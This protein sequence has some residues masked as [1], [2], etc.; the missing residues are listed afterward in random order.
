M[1][2]EK[3]FWNDKSRKKNE[4][5]LKDEHHRS[6]KKY[7]NDGYK[8]QNSK[9]NSTKSNYTSF[10][11]NLKKKNNYDDMKNKLSDKRNNKN[12]FLQSFK[13]TMRNQK[14]NMSDNNSKNN[15]S[16][17]KEKYIRSS[18]EKSMKFNFYGNYNNSNNNNYNSDNYNNSNDNNYNNNSNYYSNS[19]DNNNDNNV[20]SNKKDINVESSILNKDMY[21]LMYYPSSIEENNLNM[22]NMG[23]VNN[24]VNNYNNQEENNMGMVINGVVS[25][26]DNNLSNEYI[27]NK[28]DELIYQNYLQMQKYNNA[29]NDF[30]TSFNNFYNSYK[31][32]N[33]NNDMNIKNK[34]CNNTWPPDNENDNVLNKLSDIRNIPFNNSN[35]G[36]KNFCVNDKTTMIINEL[37]KCLNNNESNVYSENNN[38]LN[39]LTNDYAEKN[40][41]NEN[42]KFF[43]NNIAST[44]KIN[45]NKILNE[46]NDNSNNN[47]FTLN[48]ENTAYLQNNKEMTYNNR[49]NYI[50]NDNKS[51][52]ES[53]ISNESSVED[54]NDYDN[55]DKANCNERIFPKSKIEESLRVL[56]TLQVDIERVCCYIKHFIDP[57]EQLFQIMTNVFLDKT[58]T[59]NSKIAIFYVYNHLI[60]E[61]RNN[62]KNDLN[63]YN[64]I[65]EKGLQIFV[66]P[67]LRYILDEKIN[68]EMINKFYRCISI[69]NE[70]NIYSKIVCDQLK[71]LQK[72]PHKKIDLKLKH[73]VNQAHSLLSNEFSK[74]L[75]L[76]FILKMPSINN[77]HKKAL[78]DKILNTLFNN[79]SKETL[80]SFDNNDIEEASK[81]SDKV[82]RIFGQELILINSQMLELSSLIS[83]NH[84][85]LIKLQNSMEKLKE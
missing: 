85:N 1:K 27:T 69:W 35:N 79:L 84:E 66:I 39:E 21:N 54:V 37:K 18:G 29:N 49:Y 16:F 58:V 36:N 19:S 41:A 59:L 63:K 28:N 82:M 13:K 50:L 56:N 30:K 38:K 55:I 71:S 62:Y 52:Q 33:M 73:L 57:P 8:S 9:L 51:L 46:Y 12:E 25:K 10:S 32:N 34:N 4:K 68:I 53:S 47:F 81:I 43:L 15:N 74:F 77:E 76:N 17:Y 60:Q 14:L 67:V 44:N 3:K 72:N 11:Y 22:I 65:S 45:N 78:E 23:P 64:S 26:S 42:S 48:N 40:F 20:D 61:L 75:P 31:I 6:N 70:R 80:K 5:T 2:Y 24:N 83:D 7:N